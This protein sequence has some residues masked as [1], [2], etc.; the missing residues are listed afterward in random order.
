MKKSLHIKISITLLLLLTGCFNNF[1][2][3]KVEKKNLLKGDANESYHKEAD[4]YYEEGNYSQ[5]LKYEF[6]QLEEDL[7]YYKDISAEIAVDYNNIG[8]NYLKLKDYNNSISYYQ[9]A[10]KIDNIVL[11]LNNHERVVTYYNIASS[12]YAKKEIN[13]ALNY[14]I[15]LLK[16][17]PTLKER[18]DTYQQIGEIYKEKRDYQ[19]SLLYYKNAFIIFRKVKPKDDA[20]GVNILESIIELEKIMK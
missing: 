11:D 16:I 15:K 14:Y 7:K 2:R 6:K 18:L 19:N 8:L 1:E 20:V 3:D 9:K 10:I 4:R 5:A 12:F 13:K 17:N